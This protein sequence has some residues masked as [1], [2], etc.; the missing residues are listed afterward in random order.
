[1]DNKFIAIVVLV[2]V[3]AGAGYYL[4]TREKASDT[5]NTVANS[6]QEGDT[7]NTQNTQNT[8]STS[9]NESAENT[10]RTNNSVVLAENKTGNFALVQ[11]AR[12]SK[13]GF[14]V[15]H[16]VNSNSDS[17]ILGHSAFLAAGIHANLNIQLSSVASKEQTLVAALH[18]DDGDGKFEFPDSDFYL[19]DS[20]TRVV[21][22]VDV[23]DVLPQKE[24]EILD[25]QVNLFLKNAFGTTTLYF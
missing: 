2:I 13:P 9:T 23:V 15:I 17:E 16:R 6:N 8:G 24:A 3:V 12:L 25:S 11:S 7:Q 21:M 5:T 19:G 4:V 10:F 18:E 14:V 1:M 22:D 20:T